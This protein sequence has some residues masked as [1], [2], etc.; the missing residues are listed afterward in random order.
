M[1]LWSDSP[2]HGAAGTPST[3]H[4]GIRRGGCAVARTRRALCCHCKRE[5]TTYVFSGARDRDHG[6]PLSRVA[7]APAKL[8]HDRQIRSR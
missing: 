8:G 5:G 1:A 6:R 7:L 4:E 3:G 2:G